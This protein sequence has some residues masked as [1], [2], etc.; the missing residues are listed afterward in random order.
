MDKALRKAY[1]K[2]E[3]VEPLRMGEKEFLTRVPPVF[4]EDKPGTPE[5]ELR[6]EQRFWNRW[7]KFN[8][9]ERVR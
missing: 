4:K 8:Q 7:I 5:S 2:D 6:F 1:V 9:I 3:I